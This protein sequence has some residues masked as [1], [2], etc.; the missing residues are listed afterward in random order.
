MQRVENTP[1]APSPTTPQPAV[2]L[3]DVSSL[4]EP[5]QSEPSV[6]A[7]STDHTTLTQSNLPNTFR[8]FVE[9]QSMRAIEDNTDNEPMLPPTQLARL[10]LIPIADLFD[11]NESHW[12]EIITAAMKNTFDEELELFELLDLDADGEDAG[13]DVDDMTEDILLG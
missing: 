6:S 5:T 11:F 3:P 8:R 9:Q 7:T 10:P 12:Q 2:T 1:A 13:I 4:S